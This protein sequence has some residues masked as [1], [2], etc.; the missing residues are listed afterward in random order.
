MDATKAMLLGVPMYFPHPEAF[1]EE[2]Y[3]DL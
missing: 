2:E 1:T 3:C